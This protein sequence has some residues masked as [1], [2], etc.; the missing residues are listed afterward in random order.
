VFGPLNALET[1]EINHMRINLGRSNESLDTHRNPFVPTSRFFA[2]LD[3]QHPHLRRVLLVTRLPGFRT[4][5]SSSESI[6]WE[7]EDG[8]NSRIGPKVNYWDML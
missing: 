7:K 8:W 2:L 4:H 6:L 3:E 5:H 1:I